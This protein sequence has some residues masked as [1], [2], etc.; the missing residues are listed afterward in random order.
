M[1][2]DAHTHLGRNQHIFANAEQLLVS[3]DK[4]NIDKALVIAGPINDCPNEWML[5]QIAPHRDRLL[6]VAATSP[7]LYKVM[8]DNYTSLNQ[9][10]DR[11]NAVHY[12]QEELKKITDWYGES[13]IVACKFYT[14]YEHYYP[15]DV[16]LYL[17][18]LNE[19]GCPAIFHSG[20]CLSSIKKAKLK[21]AHPL[22][23]DEVA[24]DYPNINFVIAHMGYP[25]VKDTAEVCYKNSNVYSDISGFVYG[26]FTAHDSYNFKKSLMDFVSICP[27]KKLLFGTDYPVS[28]QDSYVRALDDMFYSVQGLTANTQVAFKLR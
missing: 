25:W 16:V 22:H 6:G 10:M 17:N 24:V 19:L 4:A 21:Y 8:N 27:T 26:D 11:S 20:D 2:I 28:N 9:G 12:E 15:S 18:K 23:L 14:G 1:I 7:A 5:E 13:K 3:M